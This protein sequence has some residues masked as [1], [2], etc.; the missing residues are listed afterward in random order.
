MNEND[1]VR[2]EQSRND[3]THEPSSQT[4][5]YG[6]GPPI[7][8]S[9]WHKL[10]WF[11]ARAIALLGAFV[12]FG[13]VV[14]GF[15]GWY[16]SRPEFC[17]SCHI[18]EPY[19]VS[20]QHSSH[21]DVS[22]I[23]CHFPP[24]AGEKI[25]G[26]MLGMVQLAKYVTRTEGP[27]PAA[28][29]PDASCLRSGCHEARLLSGRIDFQGIP[30][31]H[32]PHMEELRRGKKLRCTSCHGQIVQG[33][34]MTVT[35]STCFLCHFKDTH[36]NEGLGACTR[37]HQIPEEEIHLGGGVKFHHDLAYEQGVDCA[38]CHGDLIRGN[39]EVPV[40][41]CGVCHN[42]EDDL[43]RIDDHVFL[44]QKHVTEHK[45]DCLDCHL[46]IHHS[47]DS[48]K[49]HH[50]ASDCTSCHPDHHQE[51]VAMLK[52]IGGRSIAAQA[53]SMSV[54]RIAC[55]SCHRVEDV[56]PTGTVL[57][58]ASLKTCNACH[59]NEEV[60]ELETY[61]ASLKEA[62]SNLGTDIERV[63]DEFTAAELDPERKTAIE[64]RLDDITHDVHFLQ[65][66]NDI[67]NI[68]YARALAEAV[69]EQLSSLC[70]EL[71]VELPSIRLPEKPGAEPAEEKPAEEEPAKEE[72]AE[73]EPLTDEPAKDE[74]AKDEPVSEKED[75]RDE[76]LR[77]HEE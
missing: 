74:P 26:K 77:E 39:G 76:A 58:K 19:Y 36:F 53:S 7:D 8:G 2:P 11:A 64:S 20:W 31:D 38:S 42:R 17:R 4:E 73:D 30:F 66:G 23:K 69:V 28:E 22:C 47:L 29:I 55:P 41:R 24:G 18:M 15:A 68:H 9:L 71:K 51:Q 5:P 75:A 60:T 61:H 10:R 32:R 37:C 70:D 21:K 57:M 45:V 16:T 56:S 54:A 65:T 48:D 52:G 35:A 59:D 6:W 62:I 34:H 46:A 14:M 63:R 49:L 1:S 3:D 44:H 27:R 33:T 67:H 25:R 40:E 50:A 12:L 43:K 13:A 72:P